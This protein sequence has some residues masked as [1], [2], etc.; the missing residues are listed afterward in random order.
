M[1]RKPTN[2]KSA[3][4]NLRLVLVVVSATLTLLP[5]YWS[6]EAQKPDG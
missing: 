6:V 1:K 2:P 3:A 4:Y 5:V